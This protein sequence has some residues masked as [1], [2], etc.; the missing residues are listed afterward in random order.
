MTQHG[1]SGGEAPRLPPAYRLVTLDTV[2]S[3]NDEAKRL[4]AEGAEDGTLVWAREQSAGRGRHGRSWE[5][6]PGNLYVSLV[7]R[8]EC[9]VAEAL[10]LGFVAALAVGETLG[11]IVPPMTEL[12]YKWPNDV[13]LNG[14]KVA[15][16]LLESATGSD[17]AL[18]WL[19][20][21]LGINIASH[22]R[23]SR[24]P[25]TSLRAEG[26]ETLEVGKILENFSRYFLTW[27]NRW[28]DGGF[29]PIRNAWMHYAYGLDERIEVRLGEETVAGRFAELDA[30]G[31]LIL[32]MDDGARRTLHFGDMFR[33][34]EP[35]NAGRYR[36]EGG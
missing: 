7:T 35:G 22:P 26:A 2:A 1:Q 6:P 21:G 3:T 10:Q 9:P 15:G 5:S 31:A 18:D 12:R 24:F 23:E 30:D 14:S 33:A 29:A 34:S 27:V 32:E 36:P 13:L 8:P 20:L 4:A 25:A 17:G 19:V 28:L 16:I 11:S